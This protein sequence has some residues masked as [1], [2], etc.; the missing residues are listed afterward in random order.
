[1]IGHG[2]QGRDSI[3]VKLLVPQARNEFPAFDGHIL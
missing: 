3:Q 1:M 2:K